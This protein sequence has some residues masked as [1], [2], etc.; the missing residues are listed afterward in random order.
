MPDP[1]FIP[2]NNPLQWAH[3]VVKEHHILWDMDSFIDVCLEK[4]FNLEYNR[5][6]SGVYFNNL[7]GDFNII[8]RKN[9]DNNNDKI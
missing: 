1:Y 4:G 3:W 8:L 9:G 7:S 6:I 2:W 5:R